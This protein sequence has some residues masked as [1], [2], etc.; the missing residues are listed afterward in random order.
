MGMIR[1]ADLENQ[2]RRATVMNMGDL[3]QQGRA[4]I[5]TASEQAEKILADARAE[6]ERLLSGAEQEGRDRGY[7]AGH[8]EGLEAGRKQGFDQALAEHQ[9]KVQEVT[10]R[11]SESLDR[12][13]S[14]R[15]T[16][17]QQARKDVVQL[18][19]RIAERITRRSIKHDASAVQTQM[20]SVL[21]LLAR[22]TGLVL[23]VHPE[24]LA[25]AETVLPGMIAD[26]MN[27]AHAEVVGDPSVSAGSCI[28]ETEGR[29]VI[30]ASVETQLARIVEELIPDH[31]EQAQTPNTQQGD[32]A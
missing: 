10:Q 2:T 3:Q 18:A 15:D 20:Q 14:A 27:C 5:E 25:Y 22:P 30:D 7:Q 19:L 13:A 6:R 24:D 4:V 8:A 11:W 28:A 26:C 1:R 16:M 21:D 31:A 23:R 29:G 12:F 17:Y 32:A 9:E